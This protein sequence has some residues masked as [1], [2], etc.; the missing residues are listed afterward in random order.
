MWG[1]EPVGV[2]VGYLGAQAWDP[3]A[4]GETMGEDP[5]LAACWR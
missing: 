2:W 4:R 3:P 5:S 1:Q